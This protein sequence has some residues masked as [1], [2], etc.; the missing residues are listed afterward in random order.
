MME[1]NT[2]WYASH[3]AVQLCVYFHQSLRHISVATA[4]TLPRYQTFPIKCMD[5]FTRMAAISK[6]G[7]VTGL[8]YSIG[9]EGKL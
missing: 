7:S 6:V 4:L 3:S 1:F 5:A 2:Y 9:D 8:D